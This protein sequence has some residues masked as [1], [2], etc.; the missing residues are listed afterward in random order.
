VGAVTVW[1]AW[2]AVVLLWRCIATRETQVLYNEPANIYK[3]ELNLTADQVRGYE[4][5][6]VQARINATIVRNAGVAFWLDRCRYAAIATPL[7][8]TLAAWVAGR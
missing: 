6:N 5:D 8:F 3:P 4:M 1:L 7:V 2:V